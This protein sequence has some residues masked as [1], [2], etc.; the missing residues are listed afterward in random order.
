[1]VQAD[2]IRSE[3]A[4]QGAWRGRY[5][6]VA[7]QLRCTTARRRKSSRRVKYAILCP[8]YAAIVAIAAAFLFFTYPTPSRSF[9]QKRGMQLAAS[10]A[11]V[12]GSSGCEWSLLQAS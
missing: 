5:S 2:S 4:S 7:L 3:E 12:R 11:Q 8:R 6:T 10:V 1:M 9:P